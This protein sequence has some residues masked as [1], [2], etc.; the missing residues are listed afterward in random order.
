M[1][2]NKKVVARYADLRTRGTG[3]CY[4]IY[5]DGEVVSSGN[6]RHNK[7]HKSVELAEACMVKCGFTKELSQ[8]NP[9]WK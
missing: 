9:K 2:T 4:H 3:Y 8:R 7:T 6:Y 1:P 5:D